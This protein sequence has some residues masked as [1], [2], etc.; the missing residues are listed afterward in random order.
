MSRR[1]PKLRT[2]APLPRRGRAVQHGRS[3]CFWSRLSDSGYLFLQA[4]LKY[5]RH[6]AGIPPPSCNPRY[7]CTLKWLLT[8]PDRPWPLQAISGRDRRRSP[9]AVPH[10]GWYR[11]TSSWRPLPRVPVCLHLP[12][13]APWWCRCAAPPRRSPDRGSHS[14]K[15]A[16]R[17]GISGSF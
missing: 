16:G 14:G 4:W 12:L 8:F 3:S 5:W 15:A 13:C 7:R 17:T 10:S 1:T 9:A 11:P 6:S 2:T